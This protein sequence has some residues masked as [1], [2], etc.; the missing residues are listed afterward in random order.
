MMPNNDRLVSI[1]QSA[2]DHSSKLILGTIILTF[3]L[4]V[5][6]IMMSSDEQAS[7]DPESKPL[8]LQKELNETFPSSIWFISF[9]AE[10]KD[11]DILTQRELYELYQNT[12][13]LRLADSSGDISPTNEKTTGFLYEYYSPLSNKKVNGIQTIADLVQDHFISTETNKTL[14]TASDEEI[15]LAIHEI[16]KN[17]QQIRSVG[18]I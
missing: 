9:I 6:L 1:V 4:T 10:A 11:G 16:L 13:K 18:I 5:P 7:S 8:S 17:D 3:L 14:E 12:Q 2:I 15:K